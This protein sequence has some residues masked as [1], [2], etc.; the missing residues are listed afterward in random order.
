MMTDAEMVKHALKEG[1]REGAQR[2]VQQQVAEMVEVLDTHQ[3]LV[4]HCLV[5]PRWRSFLLGTIGQISYWK[6]ND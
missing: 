1:T 4:L 5:P 3:E 2:L 6:T